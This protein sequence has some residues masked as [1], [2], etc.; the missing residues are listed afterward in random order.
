MSGES[1][2]RMK[3][4]ISLTENFCYKHD[5]LKHGHCTKEK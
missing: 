3:F 1:A 4:V 5:F 2:A